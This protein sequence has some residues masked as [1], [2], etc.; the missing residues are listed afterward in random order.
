ML[1]LSRAFGSCRPM[2]RNTTDSSRKSIIRHTASDCSRAAY[3]SVRGAACPMVSP[4]RTT[5]STPEVCSAS[6]T[7]NATNGTSSETVFSRTPS[8]SRHSSHTAPLPMSRPTT[9]PPAPVTRKTP[10]PWTGCTTP[11][12]TPRDRDLVQGQRGAVVEQALAAQ[13]RQHPAGQPEVAADRGGGDGVRRRDDGAE[14]ERGPQ[15]H[16][17]DQ[18][19]GGDRDDGGGEQHQPDG[20]QRDRAQVA[21]DGQVRGLLRGGVQQRRQEDVEHQVGVDLDVRARPAATETRSPTRTTISGAGQPRRL[22]KPAT[23]TEPATSSRTPSSLTCALPGLV[24]Q[25][26]ALMIVP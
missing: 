23:V 2:I 12:T 15:R 26:V 20:Q 1:T 16:R 24:R 6:A 5:A 17:P 14:D 13:D 11:D 19:P 9:M 3:D 7:T 25:R 21:P 22:A 4:A 10:N 18:P 8:S